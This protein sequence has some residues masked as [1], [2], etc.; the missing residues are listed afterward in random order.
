MKLSQKYQQRAARVSR[1]TQLYR[2]DMSRGMIAKL[3]S[4]T[5][6]QLYQ[7]TVWPVTYKMLNSI[8]TR[9]TGN[10]ELRLGL[11]YQQ[12]TKAAPY[13][14]KRLK[15]EGQG[16]NAKRG[17]YDKT[18]KPGDEIRDPIRL[19]GHRLGRLAQKKIIGG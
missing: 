5:V 14:A 4:A 16:G 1:T 18:M 11:G 9:R 3:V 10:V 6:H 19:L 7:R 12:R 15:E 13:S 2:S 8:G 17:F